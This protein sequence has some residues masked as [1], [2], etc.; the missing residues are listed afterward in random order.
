MRES[1]SFKDSV[2]DV[3]IFNS[4]LDLQWYWQIFLFVRANLNISEQVK[5]RSPL[6]FYEAGFA[7]FQNNCSLFIYLFLIIKTIV[8]YVLINIENLLMFKNMFLIL[9]KKIDIYL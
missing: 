7:Q 3:D 6:M 2:C 4:N 9:Y 5:L 1:E 8:L